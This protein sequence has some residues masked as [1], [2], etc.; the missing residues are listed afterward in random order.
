MYGLLASAKPLPTAL[1]NL[2][3]VFASAKQLGRNYPEYGACVR[4]DVDIA[5]E[6]LREHVHDFKACGG[7]WFEELALGA[8]GV[9]QKKGVGAGHRARNCGRYG[10]HAAYDPAGLSRRLQ[11][12]RRAGGE[13]A[14]CVAAAAGS[15]RFFLTA[16][17]R[18]IPR[19]ISI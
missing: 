19:T 9:G 17:R 11:R 8:V 15:T 18:P 10:G 16:V 13:A 5:K 2:T 3:G 12:V 4:R 1:T 7:Y 14:G 6:S